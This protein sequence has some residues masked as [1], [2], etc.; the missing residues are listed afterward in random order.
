MTGS[1]MTSMTLAEMR[2]A[3]ERGEDLS[4]WERIRADKLAGIEPE[5]DEDSPNASELMR[6]TIEKEHAARKRGR[7]AGSG[8]TA[9]FTLRMNAEALSRWRASGKGWQTRAAEVLAKHAP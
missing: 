7:P 6:E 3:C 8:S 5:E 1:K 9:Q 4:D 2:A